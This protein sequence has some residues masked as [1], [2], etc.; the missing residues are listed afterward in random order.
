MNTVRMSLTAF[1]INIT[2]TLLIISFC[3]H[4]INNQSNKQTKKL[5]GCGTKYLCIIHIQYQVNKTR[6][7]F[8]LS[9]WRV[10][11]STKTTTTRRFD[12]FI[13]VGERIWLPKNKWKKSLIRCK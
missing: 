13:A 4:T 8:I 1:E 3:I 10:Y 2:F 5:V 7:I 6:I 12:F 9:I 11:L